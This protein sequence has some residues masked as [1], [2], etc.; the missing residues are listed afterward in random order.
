MVTLNNQEREAMSAVVA[1]SRARKSG[2][3]TS[4]IVARRRSAIELVRT[5]S[6]HSEVCSCYL[7]YTVSTFSDDFLAEM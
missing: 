7:C 3:L 2:T 1:E 6:P 5:W 4:A